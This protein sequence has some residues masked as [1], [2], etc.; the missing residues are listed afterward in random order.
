MVVCVCVGGWGGGVGVKHQVE[1]WGGLCFV[2][3]WV[4][5]CVAGGGGGGGVK[6]QVAFLLLFC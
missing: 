3:M 5:V 4:W 2:C 6:H 1:G